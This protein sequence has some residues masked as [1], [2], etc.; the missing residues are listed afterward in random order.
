MFDTDW[1]YQSLWSAVLQRMILDLC[2]G[3]DHRSPQG[4]HRYQAEQWVGTF[5][6]RDFVDVCDLLNMNST[7][8]HTR[9]RTLIQLPVSERIRTINVS[10]FDVNVYGCA[11]V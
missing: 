8:V 9:L 1:S 3:E 2:D 7:Y 4:L 5:P 11:D 10:L 6:T